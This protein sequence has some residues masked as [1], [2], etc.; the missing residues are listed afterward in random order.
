MWPASPRKSSDVGRG[1]DDDLV[2]RLHG[3]LLV[4]LEQAG[5]DLGALGVKQDADR[6]VELG[7]D[8]ADALD[9]VVVLLVRAMGEVEAGDVHACFHHLSQGLV[10]VAGRSHRA[11]YFRAFIHAVLPVFSPLVPPVFRRAL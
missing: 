9:A 11:D 4:I 10:V 3:D 8:A 7:G 2:A 5:A 1:G 6:H